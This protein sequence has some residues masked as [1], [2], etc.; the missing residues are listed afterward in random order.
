[1]KKLPTILSENIVAQSRIFKVQ[2]LALEYSNGVKVN[3]ERLVSSGN[4]AVLIIPVIECEGGL[5]LILIREYSAGV[6]RYELGFPKGK[7]DPGEDWAQATI[8]ESQEEI[9]FLP[10]TVEHLD[11]VTLAAGYMKHYTDIVLATNLVPQTAQGDE[12]EPL[13]I[14]YWPLADWTNLIKHPEFSEGR[15]YAALML[16]LQK[17]Q[18]I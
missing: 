15:A 11:K 1:M 13:E 5:N 3:Y 14:M 4:G 9:G 16:T 8:R 18:I 17:F 10:Q 12:P 2:A 7:I 6:H